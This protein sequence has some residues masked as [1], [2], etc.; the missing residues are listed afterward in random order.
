[1]VEK[2]VQSEAFSMEFVFESKR[3]ISKRES[4]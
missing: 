4:L 3:Q 2:V 1:M